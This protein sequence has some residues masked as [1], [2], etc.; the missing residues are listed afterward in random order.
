MGFIDNGGKCGNASIQNGRYTL[1][2]QKC[3]LSNL[4]LNRNLHLSHW[5]V[6]DAI[7]PGRLE[8]KNFPFS[9]PGA[10]HRIGIKRGRKDENSPP[11][12]FRSLSCRCTGIKNV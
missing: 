8:A 7:A 4:L 12:I 5:L 11:P 6:R 10:T 2:Y 3:R 9:V 1:K